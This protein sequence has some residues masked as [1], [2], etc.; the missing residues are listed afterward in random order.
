MTAF[1]AIRNR[2]SAE[3]LI[4]GLVIVAAPLF[5]VAIAAASRGQILALLAI[6]GVVGLFVMLYAPIELLLLGGI[7][8][9]TLADTRLV[10]QE[11]IYY[12]RFLPMA[13][14]TIR[15][16][17]DFLVQ[18]ERVTTVA[19]LFFIPGL[20]FTIFAVLSSIY[21]IAPDLTLQ[22][23]LSM[24]F[25]IVCLGLGL[26]NYLNTVDKMSR[27]IK[28]VVV[29][30]GVFVLV[31][32]L[33]APGDTNAVFDDQSFIRIRGYFINPNTQALMA[34]L[35]FYPLVWWWVVEK[36]YVLKRVLGVTILLWAGI[37][38]LAGSRASSVG[39]LVGGGF[40]ALLYG[41]AALRY[42]P[43]LALGLAF[44]VLV[45]LFAP[46]YG[47][48]VFYENPEAVTPAVA[49]EVQADRPY[50]L[51]RA[52][53][54]GMRSPI[55]GIGFGASD[56]VF[57]ADVPYRVSIGVYV[58]G[59]HNSYARMFVELGIL[60]VIV[61]SV[62][63]AIIL[64]RVLSSPPHIRRDPTIALMTATV[65]AGMTNAFFEEWLYGFGN[66]ST[67]PFWFFLALIPIRIMQ[68]EHA[69]TMETQTALLAVEAIH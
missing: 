41:R 16:G 51:R 34:M 66:S 43:V 38:L 32:A 13:M 63:F 68:L 33:V 53:E 62:V 48:A 14:L 12:G 21:S 46:Q 50:L 42:A 8:G 10:P 19:R 44:I 56:I 55:V 52:I 58:T 54:L 26:P 17:V 18:R 29:L 64:A 5:G 22:R 36:G 65:V 39:I 61:G 20:V 69:D 3:R 67:L 40:I 27:L 45:E 25:V 35:V 57:A 49:G 15:V 47:R 7:L 23:T 6:G 31:G 9:T 30:I 28:L 37:I 59:S 1:D 60:G 4:I 11:L 24:V 2:I